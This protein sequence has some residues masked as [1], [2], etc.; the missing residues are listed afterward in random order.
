[1]VFEN[2]ILRRIFEPKS[3]RMRSGECFIIINIYHIFN[4]T[5]EIISRTLSGRENS[6]NGRS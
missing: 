4:I 1:M 5:K 6:Q 3:M 2:R